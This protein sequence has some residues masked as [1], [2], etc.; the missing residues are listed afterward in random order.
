M[1]W[2][3]EQ[4]NEVFENFWNDR[5]TKCPNERCRAVIQPTLTKTDDDYILQA[6]CP[7]GCG[8][9]SMSREDDPFRTSFREWSGDDK[10]DLLN[11]HFQGR[12][13]WCPV[14]RATVTSKNDPYDGGN[15]VT[16]QCVRCG[17][18]L[19]QDFPKT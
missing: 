9:L 4:R 6:A 5:A 8:S 13:S 19:Q 12:I 7:A 11:F 2:T 16:V 15:I 14:D 1:A 18:Q 10:A 17:Q 3:E